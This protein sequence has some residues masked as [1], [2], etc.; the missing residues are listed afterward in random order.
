MT[1]PPQGPEPARQPSSS[2]EFSLHENGQ[3]LT[4]SGRLF[5]LHKLRT[6]HY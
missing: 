5:I 4:A 1:T 6:D 2:P 3:K